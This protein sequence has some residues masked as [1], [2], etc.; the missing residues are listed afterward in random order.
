M[1]G[2]RKGRERRTRRRW[3]GR[4]DMEEQGRSKGKK[5]RRKKK[6]IVRRKKEGKK[7]R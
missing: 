1:E 6:E 7:G 5:G 4:K 3:E 2:R